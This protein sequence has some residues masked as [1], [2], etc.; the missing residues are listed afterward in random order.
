MHQIMSVEPPSVTQH[1]KDLGDE[2]TT[3]L[4][5]AMAKNPEGRYRLC[6]DFAEDLAYTVTGVTIERTAPMPIAEALK[7]SL[8][9]R[10]GGLAETEMMASMAAVPEGVV[11]TPDTGQRIMAPVGVTPEGATAVRTSE[12][13]AKHRSTLTQILM[14]TAT[15]VVLV[16]IWWRI[17]ARPVVEK[18]PESAPVAVATPVLPANSTQP[19]NRSDAPAQTIS[20]NQLSQPTAERNQTP[21]ATP[22]PAKPAPVAA[23]SS[24]AVEVGTATQ[25]A[26]PTAPA[27]APV[28]P[29]TSTPKPAVVEDGPAP[30]PTAGSVPAPTPAPLPAR[31]VEAEEAARRAEE[32]RK[33][34]E[35]NSARKA[36]DDA[37]NRYRAAFESKDSEALK[38]SWPGLGRNELSSF[39]TFFKI[40]RTI[41]LNIQPLGEAEITATGATIRARRTMAATD[42]RGALPQ[43]DQIVRINLR[44]SGNAMV[45]ESIDTASR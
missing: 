20:K 40:A 41:K 1:R 37:L 6:R 15:V 12:P 43:Q 44:R 27:P 42:E 33:V 7:R 2:V 11:S 34:T 16:V 28:P 45:I 4:R 36:V 9:P 26:G 29:P 21:P 25:P 31:N 5:K 35:M 13:P 3:V 10:P 8:P 39:Q 30:A 18:P 19:P 32:Q 22:P 17:S 24:A 23:P 14:G 38:N